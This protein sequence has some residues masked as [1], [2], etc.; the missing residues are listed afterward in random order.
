MSPQRPAGGRRCAAGRRPAAAGRRP[1]TAPLLPPRGAPS[2]TRTQLQRW[3]CYFH[4]RL[5]D[6]LAAQA[7]SAAANGAVARGLEVARKH[8][9][10]DE[11]V[12]AGRFRMAG[13]RGRHRMEHLCS[14]HARAQPACVAPLT[15]SHGLLLPPSP[16][17]PPQ[18][19]L[20]MFQ[21][22]LAMVAWD[23]PSTDGVIQAIGA[24]LAA[25]GGEDADGPLVQ[26][27]KL[28]FN[29]LQ[30]WGGGAGGEPPS[31]S[32]KDSAFHVSCGA[33]GRRPLA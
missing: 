9:L 1:L 2:A 19:V 24:A 12:G 23:R 28:H 4:L 21:M 27:V 29:V 25:R 18:L 26:Q 32:Q 13:G 6:A 15:A 8:G 33:R 5:A 10:Q 3:S 30:V 20:L 17:L 7:D 14:R 22:Q 31:S 11:E 16:P